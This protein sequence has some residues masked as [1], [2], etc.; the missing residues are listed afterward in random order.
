MI[1]DV[2]EAIATSLGLSFQHGRVDFQNLIADEGT[3]PALYLDQ[4][5]TTN[6]NLTDSGYTIASYPV[7]LLFLYKSEID[8]TPTEH[9]TNCISPAELKIRDFINRC[10]SNASIDEI[11]AMSSF[12]FINLLDCNLSGKSLDITIQLNNT[13][14]ICIS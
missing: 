3:F 5:I 1:I 4:P 6:Y 11:S 7:K 12:E 8:W 10:N 9:D 2:I 13:Y 14:S